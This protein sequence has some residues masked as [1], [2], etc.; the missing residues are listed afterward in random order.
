MKKIISLALILAMLLSVLPLS[1]SASVTTDG[2]PI[3]SIGIGGGGSMCTPLIDPTDP[4][5]FYVTCDMGGLYC[6]YDRGQSWFRTESKGWLRRACI[7]EE[8]TIFTGGYGLYVSNDHGKTLELIYPRDPHYQVGRCG[9]NE[10]LMLADN[11]DNG[12]LSG[13]TATTEKVFFA[14][15]SWEGGF[16][17]MYADHDGGN[18]KIFYSEMLEGVSYDSVKI[19]MTAKGD[20]VYYT[21]QDILWRYNVTTDTITKLYEGEGTLKDVEW[22]GERFFLLDDAADATRILYTEDFVNWSDLMD[23]NDLTTTFVQWGETKTFTWHFK[24][25]VGND[26]DN[27]F[28]SFACDVSE[29]IMKFNGTS[30]E[31]VFDSMYMTR[32]TIN[33]EGWSYGSH[34][35]FYGICADPSDDDFCI[36]A[37]AETLYT[38]HYAN[39]NDRQVHTT[40]C[41]VNESGAYTSTGLNVQ[42]TYSVREDPF[43]PNHII[44]CTTDLGLQNSYD[45]GKSFKRMEI[46][47]G[48]WN[49]FNTCYDLCFDPRT[50]DLVYGLWSNRHDAPNTPSTGDTDWTEGKFGVSRDGGTTWDF[51][52]SSGLPDDCIPVKMSV[53]DT[54]S[55][56]TIAVATFNRGF[57]ISYDSGKTFESLNEGMDTVE[58][59]IWGEDIVL[60]ETHIYCLVSPYNC[61][62][63]YWEPA[64]LYDIDRKTGE[65]GKIDLG[66]LVLVRS[67]TYHEEKG[68]Y[69]N[70]IPSYEYG[71]FTELNNG[72]WVNKNGGIYHY[73]GSSVSC[74]F[75]CYNGIY[76]SGFAPDGTMYAVEPYGKV[77][78]GRD[79][80]FSLFAEGLFNQLKNVSFSADGDTLYITT[81]GGGLYRT[82]IPVPVVPEEPP[83]A[84]TVS[85]K[86][87][88]GSNGRI[89][90]TGSIDDYANLSDTYEITGRGLLYIQS[91]RIGT[92]TLTV[93]TSGRTRVNFSSVKADGSFVYNLKPTSRSTAYT[94]RAFIVYRNTRTGETVTVYSDLIR[95]SYNTIS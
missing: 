42:T 78:A 36:A 72:F 44:V 5:R 93:N 19:M 81:F 69:L 3:E 50:R 91:S 94:Y 47:G 58:G 11:F 40:H 17:L 16:R 79:G 23:K 77:Y 95:G 88:A 51:T 73:D 83:K 64:V 62:S 53:M 12:Y 14:T 31:W 4:N 33:D 34:G 75:E 86:V 38:L 70:V 18:L 92:R 13:V 6:S 56:L 32:N 61:V 24:E 45:N 54:G 15:T 66:E 59:L 57:F 7:T 74:V 1:A 9:W 29:G 30:F 85:L 89:V 80:E 10:N 67:L 21:F 35:P 37:T 87:S 55:A 65:V 39:A 27:I 25:I 71:W 2:Q 46:T 63:G 84:P 43:D 90:I 49:I 68:L 76:N 22:I 60:T 26:F 8:G 20:D 28:L 48:N 82:A 52:Y 41:T